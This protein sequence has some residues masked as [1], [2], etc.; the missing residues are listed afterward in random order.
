MRLITRQLTPRETQVLTL[1]AN[2]LTAKEAA[3]QLGLSTSAANLY[4]STAR[5]KLGVPNT[6]SAVAVAIRNGVIQ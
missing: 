1:M 3:D 5:I 6:A 2:G 4:L